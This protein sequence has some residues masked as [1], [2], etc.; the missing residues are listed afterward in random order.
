MITES[1]H[2]KDLIIKI[3][4]ND[5]WRYASP[6]EIFKLRGERFSNVLLINELEKSI[7][8]LNP[9][10][11]QNL[12]NEAVQKI[13]SV[14]S[15][16]NLVAANKDFMSYLSNGV[17]VYDKDKKSSISISIIDLEND[18]MNDEWIITNQFKVDSRHP[19]YDKQ[20]PDMVAFCNGMPLIVFELKTIKEEN[21]LL[22]AYKQMKNYIDFIPELF[23]YNVLNIIDN[24]SLTKYGSI[25]SSYSRYQFWRD[26]AN[27][28][29]QQNDFLFEDLLNRERINDLIRNFIF[30]TSDRE[31][32]KI[33]ASNHQYYGVKNAIDNST[34][35]INDENRNENGKAG[36]FWHTQ[37]S[38]K[39]FSML[40]LVKNLS[41]II[42]GTTFII[43]TDRNDL[44]NQLNKT[45]INANDYIGQ[46]IHQISSIE[47]LKEE[48][49]GRKRDGVYF[50]TVQK[51][52]STVGELSS[53]RNILVISDEAHRSHNNTEASF[54]Y[55]DKQNEIVEKRGNAIYLRQ[56][57]PL[58]T[59]IGFTGTPIS[60]EDK[61]TEKVF[62][63]IVS[64]YLMTN[65]ERDGIVVPIKYESRKPEA[66]TVKEQLEKLNDDYSKAIKIIE[67]GTEVPGEVQKK[68]NKTLQQMKNIIGDPDRIN[69]VARDFV[70]HYE[71]RKN[72]LKG[73]A[74]FVA[75]NRHIALDYYNKIIE[76]KPEWK[77]NI[78]LIATSNKQQDSKE[79]LEL[80]KDGKYRRLMAEEFKKEDSEFKIAIVVDMWLTGF[81]VPCLDVIYLDKPIKMHNLMQT[82]ARTNRVYNK[83]GIN[84]E[85]GLVVD[86][87]GLWNQLKHALAFYSGRTEVEV[88]TQRDISL[89]KN[90]YLRKVDEIIKEYSLSNIFEDKNIW[91]HRDNWVRGLKLSTSQIS[92]LKLKKNFVKHTK[93]IHKW[94]KETLVLLSDC[95]LFKFQMLKLV[96]NN[97]INTELGNIDFVE[98][99]EGLIKQIN[100][101]VKFDETVVI[102]EVEGNSILLSSILNIIDREVE[103]EVKYFEIDNK[104]AALRKLI[105]ITKAVNYKQSK[106]FSVKLN[107]M[108]SKYD[109]GHLTYEQLNDKIIELSKDVRKMTEDDINEQGFTMEEIAFYKI[110]S[111]PEALTSYDVETIEK[112]TRELLEILNNSEDK[113]NYWAFNEQ[114]KM[115]VR[116]ELV[117]LLNKY[118]YPPDNV[119]TTAQ[120]IVEQVMYQKGMKK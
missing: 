110:I 80:T 67:S 76:L 79:M 62:G 66:K 23:S 96:R 92:K 7:K 24:L 111:S 40:F 68:F 45:F 52:N 10:I 34:Q 60:N 27:S 46:K 53:R 113:I 8:R 87:I 35:I 103:E 54:E 25:T 105:D 90:E 118:N 74:M 13:N 18:G 42:P 107:E 61:S 112:I 11:K 63:P 41:R 9:E 20:I 86:Y 117:I 102:K 29:Q 2:E 22:D 75:F 43:V 58:A 114:A 81:D 33:I 83:K 97:I 32:S 5:G 31:Q 120:E 16:S 70:K 64:K 6:E 88:E 21:N 37:G 108:L 56:S 12:V 39:S 57:F 19:G 101:T 115:S 109:A 73:K 94:I 71:E 3:C 4:N 38:G 59:F 15:T 65:A 72:I 44:D 17:K 89:L 95:E 47:N 100:K 1:S 50:T 77:D 48:L 85:Y 28:E 14:I 78:K 49:A 106:D 104:I 82:I 91:M 119:A 99:E 98:L 84:K 69:L 51:F 116:K 36:I 30:F 55:D 26:S 93:D